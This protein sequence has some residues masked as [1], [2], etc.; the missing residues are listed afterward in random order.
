MGKWS[1][2]WKKN[3]TNLMALIC[4]GHL[5][6]DFLLHES[7]CHW[8]HGP[9][10]DPSSTKCVQVCPQPST[11]RTPKEE[12]LTTVTLPPRR[13]LRS[14]TSCV[15]SIFNRTRVN[16]LS[17]I[18]TWSSPKGDEK[19]L[20]VRVLRLPGY[21]AC[22]SAN[23]HTFVVLPLP[24]CTDGKLGFWNEMT[25]SDLGY[26]WWWGNFNPSKI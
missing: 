12:I 22:A 6:C 21:G 24:Q 16:H 19:H 1:I 25:T 18:A 9:R 20:P 5:K 11:Q 17:P 7:N 3:L 4:G 13:V 8:V 23:T 14:P 15:L 26:T 10:H 2:Y